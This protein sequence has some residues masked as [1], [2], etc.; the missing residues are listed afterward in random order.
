MERIKQR[1]SDVAHNWAYIGMITLFLF[2]VQPG[3]TITQ[4]LTTVPAKVPKNRKTTK[5]RNNK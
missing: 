4:A 1:L 2:S 3:P 5:K